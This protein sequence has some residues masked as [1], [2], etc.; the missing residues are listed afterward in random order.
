MENYALL[1]NKTFP[2]PLNKISGFLKNSHYNKE[3]SKRRMLNID[4]EID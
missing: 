2:I 4:Y 1:A 3:H